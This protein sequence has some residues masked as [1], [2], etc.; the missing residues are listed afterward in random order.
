MKV[1]CHLMGQYK[2]DSVYPEIKSSIVIESLMANIGEFVT[3]GEKDYRIQTVQNVITKEEGQVRVYVLWEAN[4]YDLY[5]DD[6]HKSQMQQKS[7]I[8]KI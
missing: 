1:V 3:I 6:C 5:I 8:V 7:K 2:R 4:D